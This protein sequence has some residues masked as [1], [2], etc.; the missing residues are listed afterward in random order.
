MSTCGD[1]DGAE[2]EKICFSFMLG[3]SP[4]CLVIQSNIHTPPHTVT[5]RAKLLTDSDRANG[6][7]LRPEMSGRIRSY[8]VEL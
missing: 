5:Q 6:E 7:A 1:L 8:S 4:T 3:F 2:Q